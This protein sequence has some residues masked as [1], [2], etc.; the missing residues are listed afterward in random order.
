MRYTRERLTE[1]EMLELYSF[2]AE[3]GEGFD[4]RVESYEQG[5]LSLDEIEREVK[6]WLEGEK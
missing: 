3:F 2:T 4:Q 6:K 5:E 1:D